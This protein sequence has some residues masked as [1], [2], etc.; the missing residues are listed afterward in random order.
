MNFHWFS[1]VFQRR[2]R[3]PG[4]EVTA[5]WLKFLCSTRTKKSHPF[6]KFSIVIVFWNISF[7]KTVI[8]WAK[9]IT[10]NPYLFV[11]S[12]TTHPTTWEVYILRQPSHQ[13][14]VLIHSIASFLQKTN[15]KDEQTHLTLLSFF[16]GTCG[17]A[18]PK[19][20]TPRPLANFSSTSSSTW[21]LWLQCLLFT[22][23]TWRSMLINLWSTMSRF[24]LQLCWPRICWV[25]SR[26]MRIRWTWRWKCGV[27]PSGMWSIWSS[28]PL[29]WLRSAFR[30][31]Q[32]EL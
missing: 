18:K 14:Q 8:N 2:L 26:Q 20:S 1:S 3:I 23:S 31:S 12:Q 25:Y 29:L 11:C 24:I 9:S 30:S 15:H 22:F 5:N 27:I 17:D 7:S 16:T 4:K 32:P 6:E 21:F 13:F 10:R 28:Q 19:Y